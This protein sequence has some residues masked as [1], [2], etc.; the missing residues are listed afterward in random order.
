MGY[1]DKKYVKMAICHSKLTVF[2]HFQAFKQSHYAFVFVALTAT[3][4]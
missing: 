2:Y 1:F 4:Y 3:K